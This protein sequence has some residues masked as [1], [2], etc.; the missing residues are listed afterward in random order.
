MKPDIMKL[1]IMIAFITLVSCEKLDSY[2]GE[3]LSVQTTALYNWPSWFW[4]E[5][6]VNSQECLHWEY[7]VEGFESEEELEEAYGDCETYGRFL[8]VFRDVHGIEDPE[9]VE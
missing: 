6:E 2:M 3:P 5:I 7:A 8:S 1:T 9:E 4:E